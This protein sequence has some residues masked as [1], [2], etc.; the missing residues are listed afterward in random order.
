MYDNEISNIRSKS[1]KKG[2]LKTQYFAKA[3]IKANTEYEYENENKNEIK[4]INVPFEIFWNLYAK[5]ID[6]KKC[7]PKWERLTDNERTICIEKLP[8]YIQ[9]T[10]DKKFRRDP[11]TYLNNKSWENEIISPIPAK[12]DTP[13]T[14]DEMLKMAET[15]PEIFK[16]YKAV[17]REGERKAVFYPIN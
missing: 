17:R 8:A 6:R 14:Y 12:I 5:K 10:P 15:N 4:T 7:E 13:K 16:K 2:G 1:G 3:K 9:S 11:E